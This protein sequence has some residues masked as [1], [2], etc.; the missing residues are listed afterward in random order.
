MPTKEK[1]PNQREAVILAVLVNGERYGLQ[2]RDEFLDRTGHDMP[3]GSLYPTM[4]SMIQK[5]LIKA[6]TGDSEHPGGGN[7]RR[8]YSLTAAGHRAFNVAAVYAN[9]ILGGLQS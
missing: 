1:P 9:A 4:D 5:G 2:I 8:Y 6:R 7:A 3:L